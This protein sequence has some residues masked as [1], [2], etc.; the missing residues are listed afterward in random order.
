MSHVTHR[1]LRMFVAATA[2]LGLAATACGSLDEGA[3]E[4]V[5]SEATGTSGNGGSEPAA[6]G[7]ATMVTVP[8]LTGISWFTRM[9][10][11]VDAYA[12]DAGVDAYM[13]GS[14]EADAA[15]QVRVIEDLLASGVDA[16]DVVPF[17]PD[18]VESV[19]GKAMEEGV[20]VITHEA[21]GIENAD[22]DV[23]AFRNEDYGRNLMDELAARMGEEG[24]Y[25]AMVGSLSSATHM[26]WV[27]AAI[28]HQEE[29]YPEMSQVGDIIETSDDSQIAY[30]RMQELLS[31]YPDLKG[32]QGSASTDVVGVGQAV[33]EAGLEDDIAVVGTGTPND[34]RPGLESGGIDLVAFWDPADAG[35]AMN[36]VSKMML[37]GEEITDGMDLGVPG[38]GAVTIDGKVIYGDEA[39]ITVTTDNMDEYDF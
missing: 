2:A 29:T 31:A 24:E 9:E 3:E 13:Q 17:Q 36:V 5:E 21:P 20:V 34:A 33:Q 28:A 12:A 15:A 8:K 25:A 37:D 7:D 35:Y 16:L 4:L 22:W 30:E 32:V 1:S 27:E 6:S 19:L 14:G 39:W 18:A 10:E 26:A 38:Y 23:E 11:G